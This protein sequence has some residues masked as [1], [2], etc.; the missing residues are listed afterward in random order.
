MLQRKIKDQDNLKKRVDMLQ[1][2][3]E[4]IHH[5]REEDEREY[6]SMQQLILQ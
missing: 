5:K 4:N 6:T 2:E 3:R 1:K